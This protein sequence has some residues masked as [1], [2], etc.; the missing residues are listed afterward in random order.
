KEEGEPSAEQIYIGVATLTDASGENFLIYDW[1]AP[2]SSVYYDYPPGPAEYSTPG[3]V[4][5]GNVEKKLQYIIQNGEIDS[6]FDT[7][8]TIG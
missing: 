7:S 8:L 3:G 4:I 6:M 1:R 2:I 5:H